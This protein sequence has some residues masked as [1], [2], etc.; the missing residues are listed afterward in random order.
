[1]KYV[2]GNGALLVNPKSIKSIKSGIL[3]IINNRTLRDNLIN[4]WLQKC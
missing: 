1:M 4:K 3:K 2:A